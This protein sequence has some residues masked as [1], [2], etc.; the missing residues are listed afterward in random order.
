M[1]NEK[2]ITCPYH[3]SQFDS[4]H[5]VCPLNG[6]RECE[7]Y[8]VIEAHLKEVDQAY[9]EFQRGAY[10]R[11]EHQKRIPCPYNRSQYNSFHDV[12]PFN[13]KVECENYQLLER[14]LSEVDK[15]FGEFQRG[16]YVRK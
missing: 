11:P 3:K 1:G 8:Q 9:G 6:E 14:R 4:F 5:N 2:R 13:G 10:Q 7:Q 12:C 15:S 16:A